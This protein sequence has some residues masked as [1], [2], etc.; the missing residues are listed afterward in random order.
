MKVKHELNIIAPNIKEGGGKKLF[1]YLLI[2]LEKNYKNINV[3]AYVDSSLNELKP[4][5]R[6]T[7]IKVNSSF[8]K[9]ILFF[10]KIEN[11]I[12]FGN[13]PPV[14]KSS[15]SLLYVQNE[16]LIMKYKKIFKNTKSFKYIF[17]KI[18]IK[19]FINNVRF[20]GCQTEKMM[21]GIKEEFNFFNV[22]IIPFYNDTLH[23]FKKNKK[24]DFCYVSLSPPHKNHKL[25]FEA[26][27]ILGKKG[28]TISLAVTIHSN[29]VS[30]IDQINRINQSKNIKIINLGVLS[31]KEVAKLYSQSTCLV[32]PSLAESF[33]MPIIE[34]AD[35]GLDIIIS[36]LPYSY[37]IV[38]TPFRI[39]PYNKYKCAEGIESYLNTKNPPK[40]QIIVK[41]DIEKFIKLI[42]KG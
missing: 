10:K 34:A 13:I 33:G 29:N 1:L 26:F 21:T 8:K 4:T 40:C 17:L 22:K 5:T 9:F 2:Y 20:V 37:S 42:I 28:H 41:N 12:Y 3:I 7:L 18:Y 32:F 23:N 39:N 31:D 14:F 24:F 19:L 11:V 35:Y 27:E 15:N 25:L 6:R 36:D 30:L 38:D 16:L